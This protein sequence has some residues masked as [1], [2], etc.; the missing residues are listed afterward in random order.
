MNFLSVCSGIEAASAAWPGWKAVAF[1]EIEKFPSALLAERYPDVPN[2][3]DMTRYAEWPD[4]AIDALVGG[5]PCQSFSVAGQRGSLTD[6]RGNLS[7][8]FCCIADRF[9]PEFILWENVPG[10]L[11]T[12]DNAFGCFLA[13]LTGCDTAIDPGRDGWSHAGVVAGPKRTA[14]WRVIDAQGFVP[15]RR[16]RVFVVAARAGSRVHPAD[17]LFETEADAFG[18]LGERAYTGPLFPLPEGVRG[19]SEAGDQARQEAAGALGAGSK[20]SGG[21]VGRREAAAGQL[22]TDTLRENGGRGSRIDKQPLTVTHALRADGHDAS[23][24]GTGRGTPL[25]VANA[26]GGRGVNLTRSNIG[27][28]IHNQS[29]LLVFDTTQITSP[30]SRSRCEPGAPCHTLSKGAHAPAIAFSCK[31][32]GADAGEISPTLRA[33][34]HDGSHAN[35]GGQLAVMMAEAYAND[36]TIVEVLRA[37]RLHVGEEAFRVWASRGLRGVQAP[38]VLRSEMHG[39]GIRCAPGEGEP[40][41]DDRALPRSEDLPAG[42][43]RALW[44]EWQD[45]RTPQRRELAEQLARELGAPVPQLPP[46]GPSRHVVRRLTPLEAERLMGQRDGYTLIN[47][48]GKPAADGPRYKALGNSM[49]MDVMR[50][51][52][53]RIERLAA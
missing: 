44:E 30:I 7:L 27:K 4:M 38:K 16:S 39:G 52:G 24:D 32:H 28:Q 23:E 43:M 3:G 10:V 41:M 8:V 49:V 15:Q 36:Q 22:I 42:A 37:L 31:D 2:L 1:A 29:P 5:T 51:I 19:D 25:I 14:A 6:E 9:D 53:E 46:H 11:S 20:R 13:E 26:E 45:G 17:V 47:Y 21:R 33:M 48:R 35:A 12:D 50:W 18:V 34:P 40:V